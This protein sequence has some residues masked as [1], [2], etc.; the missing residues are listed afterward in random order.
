MLITNMEY[1][2]TLVKVPIVVRNKYFFSGILISAINTLTKKKGKVA[3]ANSKIK[4][5]LYNLNLKFIFF[6]KKKLSSFVFSII[7]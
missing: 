4:I 7:K 5:L 6:F 3:L 1:K 2:K